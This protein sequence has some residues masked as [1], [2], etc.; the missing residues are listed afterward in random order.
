VRVFLDA[1]HYS[2]YFD[3]PNP[4]GLPSLSFEVKPLPDQDPLIALANA[5]RVLWQ[6]WRTKSTSTGIPPY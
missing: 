2:G 4:F 5:K 6:A 3:R 1:L